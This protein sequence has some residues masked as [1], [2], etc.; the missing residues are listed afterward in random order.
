MGLGR[1]ANHV[2]S[3]RLSRAAV[4]FN[5]NALTLGSSRALASVAQWDGLLPPRQDN[6]DRLFSMRSPDGAQRNPGWMTHEPVN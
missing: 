1:N 6:G 2:A 4:R 5:D 3:I